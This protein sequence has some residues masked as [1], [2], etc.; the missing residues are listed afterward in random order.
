[1]T[2]SLRSGESVRGAVVNGDI[3]VR[4]VANRFSCTL[5]SVLQ[6]GL[7]ER[8]IGRF[9]GAGLGLGFVG[10]IGVCAVFGGNNP[11]RGRAKAG[12]QQPRAN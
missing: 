10:R 3:V 12:G 6:R 8:R 2:S 5:L 11:R 4:L 9:V 7:L 1:M